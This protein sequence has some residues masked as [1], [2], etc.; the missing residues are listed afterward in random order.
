MRQLDH[1]SENASPVSVSQSGL[2]RLSGPA[3]AI[4]LPGP[5]ARPAERPA[6][7]PLALADAGFPAVGTVTGASATVPASAS[8]MAMR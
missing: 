6:T 7:A 4:A 3:R 5:V 2:I 1:I 8:D